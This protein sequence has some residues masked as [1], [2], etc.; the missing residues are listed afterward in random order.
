MVYS[1]LI[2][3]IIGLILLIKGSDF[4][5]ESSSRIAKRLGVSEFIIGLTLVAIG[6]SIPEFSTA[7][8]ASL[9]GNSGIIIG[10]IIGSN[11]TNMSLILGIGSLI[12]VITIK[13]SIFKKDG[14][15]MVVSM[16]ML[17]ILM[18]DKVITRAE[19]ALLLL[20]FIAYTLFNFSSKKTRET[21]DFEGFLDY[22]LKFKYLITIKDKFIRREIKKQNPLIKQEKQKKQTQKEQYESKKEYYEFK[23]SFIKD[24]MILI[25]GAGAIFFGAKSLIAESIWAAEALGISTTIIGAT[26]IALGT[27]TP[28][29]GVTIRAAKK[30]YSDLI[31]GNI[32]G[33]CIT[34]ILLV[35]G[36]SGIINP[37]SIN[38][39]TLIFTV[40]FMILISLILLL[41]MKTEWRIK[42]KEGII[43]LALYALFFFLIFVF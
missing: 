6:T 22:F 30:G 13:K 19:G 21:Y 38:N 26:L 5:V 3:L 27:T 29:L 14:Y 35:I 2:F 37:V 23:E 7:I 31:I 9:K 42:K 36:I 43:L 1:H 33:S 10:D 28:E 41:F 20:I 25:I 4:F 11:I 39:T 34:N 32:F 17:F 16:A 12:A 15:I 24:L 8:A 18:L 40:P